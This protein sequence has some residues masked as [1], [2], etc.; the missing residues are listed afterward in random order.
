MIRSNQTLPAPPAPS[1]LQF[2]PIEQRHAWVI[3]A[4][5]HVHVC[6]VQVAQ[7]LCVSLNLRRK[8]ATQFEQCS[9]RIEAVPISGFIIR[10][11]IVN[12]P[13]GSVAGRGLR[14]RPGAE[15]AIDLYCAQFAGNDSGPSRFTCGI[16][17]RSENP[18]RLR[19]IGG[20]K[21]D[22]ERLFGDAVG[23][24]CINAVGA[25]FRGDAR[26]QAGERRPSNC[27]DLGY[28]K[29]REMLKQFVNGFSERA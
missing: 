24:G 1:T 20:A 10:G 7:N 6:A 5:A 18:L 28:K 9:F 23:M 13:P 11:L 8:I 14:R 15:D 4:A 3:Q 22:F 26:Q 19:I 17:V 16:A 21:N 12:D 29:M 27:T 2:P 25:K